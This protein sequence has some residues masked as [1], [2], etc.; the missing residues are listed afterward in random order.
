MLDLALNGA[1]RNG[2]R[3]PPGP[4]AAT[5]A[6]SS[7][8]PVGWTCTLMTVFGLCRARLRADTG[9]ETSA[10]ERGAATAPSATPIALIGAALRA[11][12]ASSRSAAGR[13]PVRLLD[14]VGP[15]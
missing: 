1:A 15:P 9:T 13:A 11:A 7:P 4:R 5:T 6:G 8:P 2:N 10:T 3:A 12:R 14:M